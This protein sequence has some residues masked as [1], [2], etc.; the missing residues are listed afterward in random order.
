MIFLQR[1]ELVIEHLN[2]RVIHEAAGYLA[3]AAGPF[4]DS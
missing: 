1:D 2:M 3:A 4:Q